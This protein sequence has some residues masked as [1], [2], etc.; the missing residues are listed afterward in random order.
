MS[1]RCLVQLHIRHTFGFPPL[2]TASVVRSL[3]DPGSEDGQPTKRDDGSTE[4]QNDAEMT[5]YIPP[6]ETILSTY[7][8][9]CDQS[10]QPDTTQPD[11]YDRKRQKLI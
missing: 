7:L 4:E 6:A 9:Y 1:G 8:S 3:L 5:V 11:T 2:H 10:T